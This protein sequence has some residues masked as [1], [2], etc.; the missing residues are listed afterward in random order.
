[1][2]TRVAIIEDAAAARET[3]TRLVDLADGFLCASVSSIAE[4]A[5]RAVPE[6]SP[7]IVLMDRH[8]PDLSAIECADQLR[9]LLP[10]VP[11]V[12]LAVDTDRS[13]I[14]LALRLARLV[15][16]VLPEAVHKRLDAVG[17]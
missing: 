12:V 16:R 1:M 6:V 11:V 4:E 5:L 2:I 9:E 7:D 13:D 8:L 14:V 15:R 3:W 17:A 10:E